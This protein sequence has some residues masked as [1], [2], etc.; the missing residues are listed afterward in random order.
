MQTE[1]MTAYV[2]ADNEAPYTKHDFSAIMELTKEEKTELIQ[3]W[4]NR[5]SN[6]I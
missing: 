6:E 1:N 2:L 3:M 4:R 5:R